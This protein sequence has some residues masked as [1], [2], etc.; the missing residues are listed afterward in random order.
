MQRSVTL[1]LGFVLPSLCAAQAALSSAD[2]AKLVD[3]IVADLRRSH[4]ALAEGRFV[5]DTTNASLAPLTVRVLRAL[6]PVDSI[7]AE[8]TTP[9][10]RLSN[11]R[12][13]GDTA[14]V[15]VVVNRCSFE[16]REW[17]SGMSGTFRYMR[18]AD[19]WQ[20]EPRRRVAAGDGLRC[21]Y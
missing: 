5:F 20:S 15:D 9:R 21:P 6:R 12:L 17:V 7:V 1:V 14:T 16:P 8:R 18:T 3:T 4:T 19:G 2:S 13:S 11:I 10:L